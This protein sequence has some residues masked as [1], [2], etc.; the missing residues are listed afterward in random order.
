MPVVVIGADTPLGRAVLEA[1]S[2]RDG[3]V[4]A[5]VTSEA[6]G[7]RLRPTPVRVAVGDVSDGSHVAGAAFDCFSAVL[8]AEAASDDRDRSFLPDP[9]S[10]ME[11]WADAIG[12]AGVTRAIWVGSPAPRETTAE[13]WHVEV[14]GRRPADIAAQVADLDDRPP[15]S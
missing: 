14:E 3:E 9:G 6:A 4:R 10:V 11:A 5:F 2:G 12:E 7:T 13:T 15:A 1:I 8:I